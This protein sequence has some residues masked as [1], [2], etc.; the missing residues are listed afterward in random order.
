MDIVF[1]IGRIVGIIFGLWLF[2]KLGCKINE[3][4]GIWKPEEKPK[5]KNEEK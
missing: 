4:F 5:Q 3:H 1:M 2:Y